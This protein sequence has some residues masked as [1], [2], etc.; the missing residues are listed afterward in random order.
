MKVYFAAGTT[1]RQEAFVGTQI[2]KDHTRVKTVVFISKETAQKQMK[3]KFPDLYKTPLPSNP[4]PDAWVVTP[5]KGEMHA[6][7]RR[8]D[9]EGALPGRERRALG[10]RRPRTACSRSRR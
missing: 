10:S 5:M 3:A 8:R 1:D 6:G 7:A 4:L 9:P 2:R